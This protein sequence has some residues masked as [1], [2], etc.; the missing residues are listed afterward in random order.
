MRQAQAL[1]GMDMHHATIADAILVLI[2][3]K[4]AAE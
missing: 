3:T 1:A 2:P 4:G